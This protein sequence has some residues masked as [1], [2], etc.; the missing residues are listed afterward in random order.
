VT[1]AR[2]RN[3]GAFVRARRAGWERL[4]ALAA[5]A[6]ARRLPLAEVEELDRLYRRAAGDLAF[7]RGAFPGSDAEGYLGQV[8]ARAHAAVYRPRG[9]PW[10]RLAR[11]LRDEPPA[12]FRRHRRAGALAAALFL[13]GVGA[14]VLALVVEPA[15]AALLVPEPVRDAVA[16]HRM[17]TEHLLR[18]APGVSGSALA[19][20]NVTV[21]ALAFALG[22]TAGLGTA[23]LVVLNGL[24]LGA[25]VAHAAQGGMAGPLVAFVAAHGPAE[26]S[27][28]V[29]SAQAGFVLAGAVVDP[30]EWP[31]S[32]ALAAAGRDAVRLMALVVPVLAVVALVEATVSPGARFPPWAKAALGLSVAAAL[33]LYL[34]RA[35]AGAGAISASAPRR[36]APARAR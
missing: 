27:A 12:A 21:A 2:S 30:G 25:V 13:G 4:E 22:L 29:L 16:D 36:P 3:V 15:A 24:L 10:A 31:R 1:S 28:L 11:F 5:R 18:A 19:H 23:V 32:V 7:A 26:L 20:N 33:W 9:R 8:T 6:E 17:W 14:G 35:R 34:C